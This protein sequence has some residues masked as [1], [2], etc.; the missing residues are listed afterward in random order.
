MATTIQQLID[1]IRMTQ[2]NDVDGTTWSTPILIKAL[3]AALNTLALMRP[4]STYKVATVSM[5]AGTR[6]FLPVDGLRLLKIPRNIKSNDTVGRAIRLVS[7]K[8]MDLN[9]DWHQIEGSVVEHY[10][11]D[12]RTPK[13]YYIYPSVPVGTKIEIEYSSAPV[14]LT[15]A[16]VNA[17][18]FMPVDDVF[19][20][21][22]QELM[23][24]KLLSGDTEHNAT[25]LQHMQSA[26]GLL[27]TKAQSES[28]SSPAVIPRS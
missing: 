12:P 25:G 19:N 27:Q 5:I 14:I 21:P 16:D 13:Q 24:Y 20:Q 8:D 2:L 4:D 26:I 3:N 7:M 6:Q 1:E 23:L 15:E 18:V 28:D 9:P 11:F 17:G 22:I 10:C